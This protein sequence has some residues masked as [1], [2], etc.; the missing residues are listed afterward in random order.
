M[1][2]LY[3]PVRGGTR[4]GATR[5]HRVPQGARGRATDK[6]HRSGPLQDLS[7]LVLYGQG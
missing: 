4:P 6:L 3:K 2:R 7:G 5:I 1:R